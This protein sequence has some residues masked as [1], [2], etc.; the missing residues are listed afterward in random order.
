MGNEFFFEY[1]IKPII[2][3]EIQG[4]NL[5][6]TAIYIITL[7]FACSLI[8]IIL[9]KKISFDKKFFVSILP[10]IL[11]GVS[12]RVIMHQIE[13][14]NIFIEGIKKTADPTQLG[15]WFF[16]PGIWILTFLLT[17]IGLLISG[18][19]KK[20]NTKILFWFGTIITIPLILFNFLKFNNWI[21]FTATI[22]LILIISYTLC[23]IVNKYTK[24]K[25][26]QDEMNFFIV[27]G[28]AIDGIASTI[29]I[30]FFNFS[31]QHV[32]SNTLINIHPIL[33]VAT[34]LGLALMICWSLD[35]YTKEE[36]PKKIKNKKNLVGFIKIIIG[37]LGFATGLASL[38]KLGII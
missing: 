26:L 10:Y 20:L 8:Y 34:K 7:I 23:W 36:N 27:M 17:T 12:M 35:D 24:Y 30:T 28:Q 37:I 11:F 25:I 13:T 6:N 38:F 31:E 22:L 18:V 2:S 3:P 33:F 19:N 15:F 16:T 21:P 5:A 9:N 32:F 14:G 29:A 1:F 4:Y